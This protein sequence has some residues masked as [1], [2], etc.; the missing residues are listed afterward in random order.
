MNYKIKGLVIK[1][2]PFKEHSIILTVLTAEHGR[3]N[4]LARGAR[5]T[6]KSALYTEVFTYSEFQLFKNRGM[7]VVDSADVLEPFY[8]L[9]NDFNKLSLGQYFLEVASFSPQGS[10][11]SELLRLVLNSLSLLSESKFSDEIIKI[12]FE[13]KYAYNEGFLPDSVICSSCGEKAE[14]WLF[15]QGFLCE[16]CAAGR[17]AALSRAVCMA[18]EHVLSEHGMRAYKFNM[19]KEAVDYLSHLTGAYLSHYLDTEFKTLEY[20]NK[21]KLD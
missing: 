2:S 20:Y 7:P 16:K 1:N 11:G 17:G 19:N 5:K 15:S 12:V 10:C 6:K 8:G 13:L 3:L 4:I 18:I 14:R 9:R 21:Y